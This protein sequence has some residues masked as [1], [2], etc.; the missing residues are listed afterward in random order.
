MNNPI[1]KDGALR[2]AQNQCS[3]SIRGFEIYDR[4]PENWSIY[5]RREPL[6]DENWYIAAPRKGGGLHTTHAI[7]ISRKTGEVIY[8][9]SANNEG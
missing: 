7:I 4:M 5:L 3:P 8:D 6:P 1:D 2:I 9:G